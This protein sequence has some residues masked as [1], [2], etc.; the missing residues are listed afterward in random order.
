MVKVVPNK[1]WGPSAQVKPLKELLNGKKGGPK[2]PPKKPKPPDKPKEPAP[3]APAEFPEL[4]SLE[5]VKKLGGS[6]G[7]KLVKD[8]KTGKLYVKKAGASAE[9]LRDEANADRIYQAM[10]VKVP[11]FK[12][13]ETDAGPVKLAEFIEGESLQDFMRRA[14]K[15]EKEQMLKKIQNDFSADALLGNW[16]VVGLNRDNILIDKKGVPWRI[17]N[18]GSLRFRAQGAKKGEAWNQYPDELWTLREPGRNSQTAEIFEGL[19]FQ[20]ITKQLKRLGRKRADI[21]RDIP[22]DLRDTIA[23][24]LDVYKDIAKTAD[25]LGADKWNWDY[26]D[27]FARHS[28]GMRQAGI[29]ES[30][31]GQL[32][33]QGV[34]VR[35]E[36]DKPWDD[37]R[38][39][40]SVMYQVARYMQDNGGDYGIIQ[41]WMGR[42]AGSSWSGASQAIK[43]YV[44][45]QRGGDESPY[46]WHNGFDKAKYH[47]EGAVASLGK[48]KYDDSVQMWH[49][50]N[51]EMLRNVKFARNNIR[52]GYVE[53]VRTEDKAIMNNYGLKP[54]DKNITML[55]GGVESTSIYQ[56][57]VVAGRELTKQKVPHHRI[58]GNYFYERGP[59][60]EMSPFYGDQENEFVA[61]LDGIPFDYEGPVSAKQDTAKLWQ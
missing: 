38:G 9:H 18:G 27:G 53:L 60:S 7:A 21:L 43:Y 1:T 17:D 37:L 55:R 42:Q 34:Y 15:K 59:G 24:R 10:G 4:E 16:D 29:V 41:Y 45:Q 58:L 39:R 36:H 40:D 3:A 50:F 13:F 14:T 2:K 46:Y 25:V 8:P 30:L 35:D 32:K 57:V 52:G 5:D 19:G 20:D 28:V 11:K 23:G 31:P 26:I 51:F 54:G 61:I 49:A 12:V 48:Q 33:H 47:Y 56:T 22:K 6:T 44:S